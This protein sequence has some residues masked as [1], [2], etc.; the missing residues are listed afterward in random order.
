MRGSGYASPEGGLEQ[1]QDMQ[2]LS[3]GLG[4]PWCSPIRVGGG[5][6]EEGGL[7]ISPGHGWMDGWV[8][9]HCKTGSPLSQ[10]LQ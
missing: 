1:T 3:A 6:Y 7:G 8:F 4:M 5:G 10:R 2:G 9:N